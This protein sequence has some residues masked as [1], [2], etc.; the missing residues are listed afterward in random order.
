[1]AYPLPS[2]DDILSKLQGAPTFMILDLN[3]DYLQLELDDEAKKC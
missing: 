3:Q 1:M 2:L